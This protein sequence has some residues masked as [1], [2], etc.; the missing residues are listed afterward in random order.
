MKN[1]IQSRNA[2]KVLPTALLRE[3]Q[4]YAAGV[5]LWIPVAV[6]RALQRRAKVLALRA[7]GFKIR[8]IASI[9][10]ISIRQ[11]QSILTRD[12]REARESSELQAEHACSH[13]TTE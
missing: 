1:T 2:A 6:P 7:Q 8:E 10:G 5:S 3:V 12:R 9:V 11:T 13:D 4:R